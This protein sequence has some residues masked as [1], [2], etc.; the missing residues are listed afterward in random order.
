[1]FTGWF[2]FLSLDL[3]LCAEVG[4]REMQVWC[5]NQGTQDESSVS[6][7]KILL[8]VIQLLPLCKSL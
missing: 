1:M 3:N 5:E 6:L 4:L 7:E 8:M 2:V